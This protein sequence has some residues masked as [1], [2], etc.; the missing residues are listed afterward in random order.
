MTMTNRTWLPPYLNPDAYL[1]KIPETR[2]L[3]SRP[4][5]L[6]QDFVGR[7]LA[8]L[9]SADARMMGFEY[10]PKRVLPCKWKCSD[11]SVF[12]VD[13]SIYSY[14]GQY[15]FDK[16]AIGGRFNDGSLG[17]AVHHGSINV[18]FGGSHMGY[19]PGDKGGRFGHIW[20]PLT[21]HPSTNCGYLMSV[22]APFKEVYDDACENILLV[23]PPGDKLMISVPNE[24]IQP[25]WSST[26]IKLLVD[27]D[28]LT[29]GDVCYDA[30]K[31]HTHTPIGRTLFYLNP[32]FME[33][34]EY[35]DA[36][37]IVGKLITPIGRRLRHQYFNIFDTT[38]QLDSLGFPEQ[39]L[40]LYMKY[41][42]SAQNSPSPLKA[43]VVNTNLEYNR[44]ADTVRQAI[45]KP[46][47]FAS[48]TGIFID[49]Y[50]EKIGNYVNLFQPIGLS[51]KPGGTIQ[52]I[53]LRPEQIHE[54]FE[55]L[56]P[57]EP[58]HSLK[59]VMGYD[60]PEGLVEQFTY[61]PG[62]YERETK[63]E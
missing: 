25:N 30:E 60:S 50:D 54:V 5:F 20:R 59:Q 32:L 2:T 24:Y 31:P 12:G 34:L 23:N 36:K 27:T 51:I 11:E 10:D 46:Y 9:R 40:F 33:L 6:F 14:M 1:P 63:E 43:A 7:A 49:L 15:P 35:E 29:A 37:S 17:A 18:D 56:K 26:P 58:I 53:E 61:R 28:T 57:V 13:L 45:F 39:K 52:D 38:A 44:L 47:S 62:Y 55:R 8:F 41:I 42:L 16:G 3:F 48:F 4:P 21:E 19:V 22:L